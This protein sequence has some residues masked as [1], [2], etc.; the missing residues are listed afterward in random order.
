MGYPNLLW[1]LANKKIPHYRLANRVGI[2]ESRFSRALNG[3]QKFSTGERRVISKIMGYSER[4]LFAS[5]NV[6]RSKNRNI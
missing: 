4:W 1:I 2:S 6:P 5:P 3:R